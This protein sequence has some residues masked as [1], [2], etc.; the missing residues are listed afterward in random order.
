VREEEAKLKM[1][2]IETWLSH[3]SDLGY[4]EVVKT[5]RIMIREVWGQELARAERGG[6]RDPNGTI[7]QRFARGGSA[8][9]GITLG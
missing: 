4:F 9:F 7:T 5:C 8:S 1:R 2:P 6:R 3:L